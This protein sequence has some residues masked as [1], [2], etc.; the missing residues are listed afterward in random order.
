MMNIG[1]MTCS[2]NTSRQQ[3]QEGGSDADLAG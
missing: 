2:V 1:G 3:A